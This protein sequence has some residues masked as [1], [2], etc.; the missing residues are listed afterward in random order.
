[1]GRPREVEADARKQVAGGIPGMYLQIARYRLAGKIRERG[2]KLNLCLDGRVNGVP[3]DHTAVYLAAY[4]EIGMRD[5][6]LA[7]VERARRGERSW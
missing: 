4:E 6:F 3:F 5:E 7:E 2:L 1:M